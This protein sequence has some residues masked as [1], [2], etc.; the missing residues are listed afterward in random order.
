MC[1]RKIRDD[2]LR[3]DENHPDDKG[4]VDHKLYTIPLACY[5]CFLSSTHHAGRMEK[6]G[7]DLIK[8]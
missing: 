1:A 6:V 5:P 7:L 4:P 8:L 3:F 2:Q